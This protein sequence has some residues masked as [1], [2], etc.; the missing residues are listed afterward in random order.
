LSP[1]QNYVT[2]L[3][4]ALPVMRAR[5]GVLNVYAGTHSFPPAPDR[6]PV[7]RHPSCPP[8]CCFSVANRIFCPFPM[9]LSEVFIL[10]S[11][12]G[13]RFLLPP[14]GAVTPEVAWRPTT[15]ARRLSFGL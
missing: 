10:I 1:T 8:L 9:R 14:A 3:G 12:R 2:R 6:S 11:G 15:P 7:V 13:R 4:S 5:G